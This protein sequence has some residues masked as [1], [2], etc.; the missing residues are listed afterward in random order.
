[1]PETTD[2]PAVRI[3]EGRDGT[4]LRVS[5]TLASFYRPG[6]AATGLFWDALAAPVALLPPDERRS[7]LV[8]GLGGGSAARVM[9]ALAPSALIVGIERSPEVVRAAR[10]YLDLDGL[11]LDVRVQ[12]ARE[13]L[14]KERGPID[15]V[16]EDIFEGGTHNLRKPAWLLEE[17][18]R[19]AATLL[20]P[21]GVFISNTIGQAS[22]VTRA[23][24]DVLPAVVWIES[25]DYENKIVVAGSDLDAPGLRRIVAAEPLL[26]EIRPRLRFRTV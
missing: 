1:M 25:L 11:D 4:E 10:Q 20:R 26:S 13:F 16:L 5:G 2:D 7:I 12:D 18:L 9:R 24:R 8:L 19:Q 21:G 23:V 14:A 6:L 3:R 22:E 15:A 17:G